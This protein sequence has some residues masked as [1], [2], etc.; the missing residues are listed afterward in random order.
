MTNLGG[1]DGNFKYKNIDTVK[2]VESFITVLNERP[3]FVSL[4]GLG[5]LI[6]A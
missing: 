5:A 1:I 2:W 3:S 4:I 6:S